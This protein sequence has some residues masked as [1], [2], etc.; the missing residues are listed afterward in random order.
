[1]QS[2]LLIKFYYE[3][4][5]KILYGRVIKWI[6]KL[7]WKDDLFEGKNKTLGLERWNYVL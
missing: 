5:L 6:Y 3:E 2:S 4:Q 7:Q 1:M